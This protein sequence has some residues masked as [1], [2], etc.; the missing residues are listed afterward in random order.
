MKVACH[1]DPG[2]R[3]STCIAEAMA[4]GA[5]ACGDEASLIAGFALPPFGSADVGVAYGWGHPKMFDA[6]RARGGASVYVD[7]GWWDRKPVGRELG[8]FHKVVVNGREPVLGA[9]NYPSD[10]FDAFGL[11]IAPWRQEGRHVVLAG[12]S[13][14]SAHTRGYGPQ[15][16]ELRALDAIR[17]A[18]NLPVLYKPKP[19]WLAASP[20]PDT[21]F[22]QGMTIEQA[23]VDAWALVTLHS[24]TAVDALLA[25]VPVHVAE[26]VAAGFSTPLADLERP[27]YPEGRAQLMANIAYAQ[28]SVPEIASGACWAHLKESGQL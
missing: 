12:M 13:A 3:R 20:I 17:Q 18:T 1:F 9:R 4:A 6:Y 8:G 21:V 22:A 26:G 2:N 7:L 11:K 10:R 14:K 19:S 5:R 28:W 24:N 15:E 23:L 25:G 27:R 16:W